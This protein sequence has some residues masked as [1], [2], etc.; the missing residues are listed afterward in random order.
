[1]SEQLPRDVE[2]DE[3]GWFEHA[4]AC[5]PPELLLP[6]GA[7]TLPRE[8]AA[9]V[10]AHVSA[11]ATCRA[12]LEA[13]I[14]LDVPPGAEQAD[15]IAAAIARARAPRHPVSLHRLAAPPSWLAAAAM[16]VAAAGLALM[17]PRSP[18][19]RPP[20][21]PPSHDRRLPDERFALSLQKPETELP[22][23]AL[24]LRG[25]GPS[26][27]VAAL[28]TALEPWNR[29]RFGDAAT[30]F[31]AVTMQYPDRPHGH[32]Y[33]GVSLLMSNR[34]H[35]AVGPLQRA[36]ALAT[37]D[38]SLCDSAS[39]YLA[40]GFERSGQIASAVQALADLCSRPGAR[41]GEACRG[42]AALRPPV[43]DPGPKDSR[44]SSVGSALVGRRDRPAV[45]PTGPGASMPI[46]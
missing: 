25:G 21:G 18:G 7:G 42:L 22:P 9:R 10:Q 20:I 17:I 41:R 8:T 12:L 29:D 28:A 32:Y 33:L 34:P 30:K 16:L 1:M 27:Y 19:P 5:V 14:A 23:D 31:R 2:H 15:R 26:P 13:M 37:D 3:Q 11:C 39:W 6:L 38:A 43:G 40:I 24:V 36:Q 44:T 46:R 4:N 45:G 35:E